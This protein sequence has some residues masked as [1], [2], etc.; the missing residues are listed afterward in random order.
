MKI[1]LIQGTIAPYRT[2]LFESIAKTEGIDFKVIL[3]AKGLKNVPQWNFPLEE[4]SFKAERVPGWCFYINYE[5]QI[6]LNP[7]LLTKMFRERPDVIVCAGF[8]FATLLS[9]IYRVVTGRPY[10]IWNE[11]TPFTESKYIVFKRMLR[12]IMA[13]FASAFIAAGSLSQEYLRSLLP[14]NSPKPFFI[15]YNCP[16]RQHFI[17]MCDQSKNSEDFNNN[18]RKR[19]PEKNILYAGKLIETKGVIQLL[20]VYDEIITK[21]SEQLGL[22]LVGQGPLRSLI[23]NEKKKHDWK[24]LFLEGFI[25][26]HDLPKYYAIADVFMLLSIIDRNPLVIIEALTCGVPIVCS[27]TVGNAF[28]F[29]REGGNGYIVNS[30]D[31]CDTAQKT[32]KLLETEEREKISNI[33]KKIAEKIDYE[34]SAKAFIDACQVAWKESNK[35][36]HKEIDYPDIL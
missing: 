6:C 9:L 25:P 30:M 33:S 3:L 5:E 31:I 2:K 11:G 19:F 35:M 16:D 4:M 18:F 32:I 24:Y 21:Y 29:I 22:I 14:E 7:R 12:K 26:Y 28:D 1:W 15:S 13:R 10:V 8:S 23:E 34:D 17:S 36:P 27:N 20:Q